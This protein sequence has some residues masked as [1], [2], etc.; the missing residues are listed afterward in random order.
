M[1]RTAYHVGV[2]TRVLQRKYQAN[3]RMGD[4]PQLL[5]DD[6]VMNGDILRVVEVALLQIVACV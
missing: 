1:F 5:Y 3:K 4:M 2:Y 6:D